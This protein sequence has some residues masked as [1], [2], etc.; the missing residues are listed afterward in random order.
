MWS[1]NIAD[2]PTTLSGIWLYLYLVMDVWG[3]KVV[4]WVVAERED[5]ANTEDLVR[6]TSLKEPIRNSRKPPLLLHAVNSNATR[7]D[8]LESGLE[9]LGS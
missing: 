3:R 6:S 7:E 2:L 1:W 5:Q 9:E 8:M 4:T